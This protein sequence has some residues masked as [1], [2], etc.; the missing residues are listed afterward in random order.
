[1]EYIGK[2]A[3]GNGLRFAVGFVFSNEDLIIDYKKSNP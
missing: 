1:V 3:C 2:L